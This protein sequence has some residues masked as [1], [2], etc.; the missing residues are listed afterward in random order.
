MAFDEVLYADDTICVSADTKTMNKLLA[1]IEAESAKYGLNSNKKKCELVHT[2][3]NPNVHFNGGTRIPSKEEVNYLG[4]HLNKDCDVSREVKSRIATCMVV[5]KRLDSFWRHS[6]CLDQFKLTTLDAV[7]K[8]KVLYGLESAQLND[9]ILNTLDVFQLKGLRKILEMDTTYVNR[10]NTNDLVYKNANE[11]IES[12]GGVKTIWTFSEDYTRRKLL[13]YQKIL[14]SPDTDPIKQVT[15]C[16]MTLGPIHYG[17]RRVGRPRN[18]WTTE[19]GKEY[20]RTVRNKLPPEVR[21]QELNLE[22]W[23]HRVALRN[24]ADSVAYEGA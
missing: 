21:N 16:P 22:Y 8:S 11:A 19:A 12:C 24:A 15:F 5:L 7:I 1:S 4:C 14:A 6:D 2:G 10:E 13:L 9:N 18:R 20:W 23:S 17:V 3:R